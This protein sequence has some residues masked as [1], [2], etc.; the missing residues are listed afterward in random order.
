MNM[1]SGLQT[2]ENCQNLIMK[3]INHDHINTRIRLEI[4]QKKRN[5]YAVHALR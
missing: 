3:G 5:R 1:P 4:S 2:S